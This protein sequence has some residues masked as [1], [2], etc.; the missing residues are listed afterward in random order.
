MIKTYRNTN[1]SA[2]DSLATAGIV[3][4]SGLLLWKVI[5]SGKIIHDEAKR[6]KYIKIAREYY[7]IT[8]P[9]FNIADCLAMALS[10][11]DIMEI[12]ENQYDENYIYTGK[13][14]VKNGPSRTLT[15][16]DLLGAV[17]V[18]YEKKSKHIGI[19]KDESDTITVIWSAEKS[20]LGKSE[21]QNIFLLMSGYVTRDIEIMI[22]KMEQELND[23]KKNKVVSESLYESI[24]NDIIN[25]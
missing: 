21:I 17:I 24:M 8:N 4:G 3:V 12:L 18:R 5:R 20:G 23:I 16:D 7:K 15:M 2:L 25:S 9:N 19:T 13:M 1:E 10:K 6:V 11:D 14:F 22:G